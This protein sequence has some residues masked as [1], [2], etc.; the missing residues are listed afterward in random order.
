MQTRSF[1]A[2]AALTVKGPKLCPTLVWMVPTEMERFKDN[3]K[4]WFKQRIV[5]QTYKVVFICQHSWEFAHKPFEITVPRHW[6]AKVMPLLKFGLFVL[7]SVVES[8]HMP[9]PGF[10]MNKLKANVKAME[11]FVDSV[12]LDNESKVLMANAPNWIK[13]GGRDMMM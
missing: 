11:E 9:C 1:R 10:N 3:P 12:D 13:H 6:V 4:K 7:K 5:S 8:N 2:H